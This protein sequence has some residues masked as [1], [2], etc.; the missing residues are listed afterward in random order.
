LEF[1][2]KLESL[3]TYNHLH[4]YSGDYYSL[5]G[6]NNDHSLEEPTDQSDYKNKL[7]FTSILI[8]NQHYLFLI[9]NN[10]YYS[11]EQIKGLLDNIEEIMNYI[12]EL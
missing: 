12:D 9:Y 8:N 1:L 6:L 2:E 5:E 7:K 4:F 3:I 10:A 11:K